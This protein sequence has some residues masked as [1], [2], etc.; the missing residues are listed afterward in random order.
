EAKQSRPQVQHDVVIRP[1]KLSHAIERQII[2]CGGHEHAI[3]REQGIDDQVSRGRWRVEQNNVVERSDPLERAGEA[4]WIAEPNL[5]IEIAVGSE[6]IDARHGRRADHLYKINTRFAQGDVDRAST[7]HRGNAEPKAS[8]TLWIEIADQDPV[9]AG[10]KLSCQVDYN[11]CLA[12]ATF[13]IGDS[14][15]S[16]LHRTVRTTASGRLVTASP[17]YLR[18][19]VP[20]N[21]SRHIPIMSWNARWSNTIRAWEIFCCGNFFCG[22]RQSVPQQCRPL[23]PIK[24][25]LAAL[26]HHPRTTAIWYRRGA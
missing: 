20:A 13:A 24:R 25:T 10:S 1:H 26:G 15:D 6:Q 3:R 22:S 23:T 16:R 11:A 12:G 18:G 8:M 14:Q 9:S 5:T 19:K 21:D 17:E 4:A 7:V 2:E